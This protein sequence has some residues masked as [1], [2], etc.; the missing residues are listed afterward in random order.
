MNSRTR[1][2]KFSVTIRIGW[3]FEDAGRPSDEETVRETMEVLDTNKDGVISPEEFK[4]AP[5]KLA[6]WEEK[7]NC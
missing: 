1:H 6:W 2:A 5:R 3:R 7:V 4:A